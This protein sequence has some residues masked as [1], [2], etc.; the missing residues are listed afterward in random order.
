LCDCAAAVART[1][2]AWINGLPFIDILAAPETAQAV[3]EQLSLC[4]E[5]AEGVW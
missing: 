2:S 5:Y 3:D 4:H 1:L